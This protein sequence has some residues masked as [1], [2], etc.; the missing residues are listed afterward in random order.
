MPCTRSP[1]AKTA[2]RPPCRRTP[3]ASHRGIGAP[4]PRLGFRRSGIPPT[5]GA[6]PPCEGSLRRAPR[7]FR[8]PGTPHHRPHQDNARTPTRI[9]T[10]TA[11]P[12]RSRLSTPRALARL[13]PF[14]KPVLPRLILG[15]VSALI[16]SLLALTD[17]A[18]P[19]GH[20]RGAD[21]LGRHPPDRLGLGRSSWSSGS[22]RRSWCGLRRWFVLGP[23]TKVEYDLRR[24]LLRAPAATARRRSTTGGSPGSCSAA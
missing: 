11:E 23:A 9:M 20:R 2:S 7:G 21:R 16:A 18:R 12:P 4:P 8:P 19:R 5:P 24:E 22:P 6:F 10:L 17:P 1:S 15:A 14:A 13:L 3:A